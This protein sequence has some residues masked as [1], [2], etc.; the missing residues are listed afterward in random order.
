MIRFSVTDTGI[1]IRQEDF[2]KLFKLFGM[3]RD[4]DGV[5][6]HGVGL[7][8]TIVKNLVEQHGGEVNVQSDLG[9]GSQ[10]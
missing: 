9:K 8:L 6:Q 3:L 1:G 7:G 10:F 2:R 5:N 4:V